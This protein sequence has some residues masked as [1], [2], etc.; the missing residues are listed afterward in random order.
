MLPSSRRPSSRRTAPPTRQRRSSCCC[1]GAART[2]SE[3]LGLAPH[4]P[5]GPQYAAVRAP[6][7]EGGGF[8]WFANRGIGRPVAA[9]LRSTMDWF[10]AWLDDVAPEG[11]PVAAG[12][13]QRGRGVRRRAGPRRPG[14][15]RRARRSSTA[16]CRS[17]PASR[18]SPGVSRACRSSS[19]RATP[20]TSS[21]ASSSTA[22]GPT[23]TTRPGRTPPRTAGRAGTAS[24]P[25]PC[26]E[27]VGWIARLTGDRV[28]RRPPRRGRR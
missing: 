28:V 26:D 16:P 22:P 5:D 11:R 9:S 8:A 7:A 20:T 6:I 2:S 13:L 12:R 19:P 14:A 4:L 23:C 21:P 18:S 25:R 17:T 10:R 15:V 24:H 3:I 1:T 27:L